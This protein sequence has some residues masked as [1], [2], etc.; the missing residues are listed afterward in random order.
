MLSDC[1]PSQEGS[2][3]LA[4]GDVIKTS[5]RSR[6]ASSHRLQTRYG[7]AKGA[8]QKMSTLTAFPEKEELL[9]TRQVLKECKWSSFVGRLVVPSAKRPRYMHDKHHAFAT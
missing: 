6:P 9:I 3:P 8:E 4:L 2:R 7:R 1:D 5:L